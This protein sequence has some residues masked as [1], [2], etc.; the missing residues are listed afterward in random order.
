M[1][2]TF[3]VITGEFVLW[4]CY[5]PQTVYFP[6]LLAFKIYNWNWCTMLHF[7]AN[8]WCMT[9]KQK[10]LVINR[11]VGQVIKYS[12]CFTLHT[13]SYKY[14][15]SKCHLMTKKCVKVHKFTYHRNV[16]EIYH[17]DWT[18]KSLL[19]VLIRWNYV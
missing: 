10:K 14:L 13:L 15:K 16:F 8:T 11:C 18:G 4:F 19:K 2:M 17:L 12:C 5:F 1:F 7:H 3:D 9:K 6:Y